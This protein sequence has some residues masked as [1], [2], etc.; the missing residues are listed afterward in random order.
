M[1]RNFHAMILIFFGTLLCPFS[2]AEEASVINYAIPLLIENNRVETKMRFFAQ[3][4]PVESVDLL[5]TTGDIKNQDLAFLREMILAGNSDFQR[6]K[7][8]ISDHI[9]AGFSDDD[10]RLIHVGAAALGRAN[11]IDVLGYIE[12]QHLR[13]YVINVHEGAVVTSKIVNISAGSKIAD[14]KSPD[15]IH[16]LVSYVFFDIEKQRRKLHSYVKR[17]S[18]TPGLHC[19]VKLDDGN[20]SI[21]L[22]F[23]SHDFKK[24]G[25]GK[26]EVELLGHF[27]DGFLNMGAQDDPS[28]AEKISNYI[29]PSSLRVLN[30]QPG[31]VD[32]ILSMYWGYQGLMIVD[33]S[34]VY[35][36]YLGG[37]SGGK[38]EI[39]K[40]MYVYGAGSDFKVVN[41]LTKN[42]LDSVFLW[43]GFFDSI[44]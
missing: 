44:K 28:K 24:I 10:I 26:S 20:C 31:S 34:P 33:A 27:V 8:A 38:K 40:L 15:P 12:Q 17:H 2:F 3:L 35:L 29:H 7:N 42:V 5:A 43:G 13:S 36:V 41:V 23:S 22:F 18:S 14:W 30:S 4:Q 37:I 1:L 21:G 19:L 25:R 16:L 11:K 6:F 39:R 9:S 32:S